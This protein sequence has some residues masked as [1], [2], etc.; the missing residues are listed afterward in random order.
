M[1]GII[2]VHSLLTTPPSFWSALVFGVKFENM[3]INLLTYSVVNSFAKVARNSCK[4][5]SVNGSEGWF[6]AC[7]A[8]ASFVL[9]SAM[10]EFDTWIF[11]SPWIET[12][13]SDSAAFS[14]NKTKR[15]NCDLRQ[16]V[17]I[18]VYYYINDELN[19]HKSIVIIWRIWRIWLS[20]ES[21]ENMHDLI[22][23]L[24]WQNLFQ[25]C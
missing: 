14:I 18:K 8:L 5:C 22:C 21:G 17:N 3:F 7:N 12:D 9:N 23:L 16:F 25:F 11:V 20:R 1:C 24:F 15:S 4:S 13:F 2:T 10:V 6:I 19:T